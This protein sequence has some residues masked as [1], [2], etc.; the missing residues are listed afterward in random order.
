VPD[1][2]YV[3]GN[4][5]TNLAKKGDI[6]GSLRSN[7]FPYASDAIARYSGPRVGSSVFI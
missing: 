3:G 1:E 4:S 2:I 6:Y 7:P 5:L